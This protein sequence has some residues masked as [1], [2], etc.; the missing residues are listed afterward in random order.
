MDIKTDMDPRNRIG[1]PEIN[2]CSYSYPILNK[3]I[4]WKKDSLTNDAWKT[5][6][7]HVEG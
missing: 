3:V 7:P 5:G 6:Y 2:S 1:D 4:C